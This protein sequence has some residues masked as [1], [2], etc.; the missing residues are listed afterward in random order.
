V[1][2]VLLLSDGID[3]PVAGRMMLELGME[4]VLLNFSQGDRRATAKVKKLA[5]MLDKDARLVVMDHV[6]V[7]E[8]IRARC[9][10][11]YQCVLCKRDMY[12]TAEK[13]AGEVGARY[14]VT[15]ENLGQ[16]ASQTPENLFALDSVVKKTV[17]RPL[18]G[19][20]KND[21]I[22][23]ARKT[24]T[25]DISTEKSAGCMF[26]P[27]SPVTKARLDKVLSEERR[28]DEQA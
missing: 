7:Q 17:L 14:I 1:K 8:R 21:I 20:D 13:L 16:V 24:G 9:R 10:A 26:V 22:A 3:S 5:K 27:K 12:R 15:G 19:L 11:R 28:L 4:L 6:K 23:V 18:L 2:G 25:Y